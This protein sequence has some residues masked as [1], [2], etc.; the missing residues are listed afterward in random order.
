VLI[1]A[2]LLLLLLQ[3]SPCYAELEGRVYEELEARVE[4][5]VRDALYGETQ[6]ESARSQL[7]AALN[8]CVCKVVH[9]VGACCLWTLLRRCC[10]FQAVKMAE[11][12]AFVSGQLMYSSADCGY[13]AHTHIL[14]RRAVPCCRA[15]AR[16]VVVTQPNNK[17]SR[18]LKAL[19]KE[20]PAQLAAI[21][22]ASMAASLAMADVNLAA[23]GG[24]GAAEAAKER[25]QQRL[26]LIQ[27][28]QVGWG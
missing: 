14:G 28:L 10:L 26:Q 22:T 6:W 13:D 17:L 27:A 3:V 21:N 12:P 15:E 20:V 4:E 18:I 2:L 7:R 25:L 11:D 5:T 1:H 8:C 9:G 19:L 24:P 16:N 23:I